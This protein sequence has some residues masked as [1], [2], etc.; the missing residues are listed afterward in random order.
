MFILYI[1][2]QFLHVGGGVSVL[3]DVLE[4]HYSA[5]RWAAKEAACKRQWDAIRQREAD[6]PRVEPR[7]ISVRACPPPI[8]DY[9]LPYQMAPAPGARSIPPGSVLLGVS[10]GVA[11]GYAAYLNAA[12]AARG[13]GKAP[14]GAHGAGGGSFA[15][16]DF[17]AGGGGYGMAADQAR[18]AAAGGGGGDGRWRSAGGAL[19]PSALAPP[20][21]QAFGLAADHAALNQPHHRHSA[22]GFAP[23][24]GG[25]FGSAFGFAPSSDAH[26]GGSGGPAGGQG[27]GLVADHAAL[28]QHHHQQQ[29]HDNMGAGFGGGGVKPGASAGGE[30]FGLLADHRHE[31]QVAAGHG[32]FADLAR[33]ERSLSLGSALSGGGGGNS[34]SIGGGAGY[35]GSGISTGGAIGGGGGGGFGDAYGLHSQPSFDTYAS[36]AGGTGGYP[37][38]ASKPSVSF[39]PDTRGSGYGGAAAASPFHGFAG[40]ASAAAPPAHAQPSP[41]ARAATSGGPY[42]AAATPPPTAH[43]YGGMASAGAAPHASAFSPQFSPGSEL[44]STSTFHEPYPPLPPHASLGQYGGGAY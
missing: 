42:G 25:A 32:V 4:G 13:A 44:P 20:P 8:P 24:A 19:Q 17:A 34:A 12:A 43:A 9:Q 16:G 29:S 23:S 33:H 36:A 21:G 18:F 5:E 3:D 10:T 40:A 2:I 28:N 1:C 11:G 41:F 30:Q 26:F 22:G 37:A 38:A 6:R 7:P 15:A 14:A 39:A 27:F 31:Q 35:G